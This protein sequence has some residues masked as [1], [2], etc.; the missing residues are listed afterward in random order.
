MEESQSPAYFDCPG[1][2][3]PSSAKEIQ[4]V[5]EGDRVVGMM[6]FASKEPLYVTRQSDS[7]PGTSDQIEWRSERYR[8]IQ[9]LPFTDYGFNVVV[10]SRMSGD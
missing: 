7:S 10:G 2:V 8:L 9:T 1:V 6:T 4:Q 3:W 5:P